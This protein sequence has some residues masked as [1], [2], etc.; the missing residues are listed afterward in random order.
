MWLVGQ[1]LN[2]TPLD[3]AISRD[4]G[5]HLYREYSNRIEN[6]YSVRLGNRIRD[7]QRYQVS[8][9][10]PY[11]LKCRSDVVLEEGEI[12]SFPLRVSL[13]QQPVDLT[14]STESD[15]TILIEKVASFIAR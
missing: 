6:V 10:S 9:D 2:R 11:E 8:V 4:R 7:T 12:F 5:V 14:V 3:A 1:L 13:S 15:V